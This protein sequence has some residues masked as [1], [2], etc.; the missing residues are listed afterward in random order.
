MPER[1]LLD[2]FAR[3]QHTR[4]IEHVSYEDFDTI[5]AAPIALNLRG[6]FSEYGM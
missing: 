2:V 5:A 6:K 1:R 3:D 4:R